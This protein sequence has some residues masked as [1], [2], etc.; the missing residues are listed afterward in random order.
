MIGTASVVAAP[1]PRAA[2]AD[3]DLRKLSAEFLEDPYPT[4]R[5]LRQFDPIHRHGGRIVFPDPV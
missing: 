5:A 2:A 3:F 1:A 4:Y